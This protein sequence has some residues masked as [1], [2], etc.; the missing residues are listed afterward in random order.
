MKASLP[1]SDAKDKALKFVNQGDHHQIL[2][3]EIVF[4]LRPTTLRGLYS[5]SLQCSKNC[6]V[7]KNQGLEIISDLMVL[8]ENGCFFRDNGLNSLPSIKHICSLLNDSNI[9][10]NVETKTET[11]V[12]FVR[13]SKFPEHKSLLNHT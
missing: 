2:R 5:L 13:Q 9:F 7:G 3:K 6:L 12:S 1:E 8:L 4:G 11:I 10:N